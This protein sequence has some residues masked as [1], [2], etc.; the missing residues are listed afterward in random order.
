[1]NKRIPW[2]NFYGTLFRLLLWVLKDTFHIIEYFLIEHFSAI[3]GHRTDWSP[4][5]TV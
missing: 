3:L 2:S 5:L 4:A 1:M